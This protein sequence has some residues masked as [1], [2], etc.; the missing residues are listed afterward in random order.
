MPNL[1]FLFPDPKYIWNFLRD[2]AEYGT[3]YPP[4]GDV[5]DLRALTKYELCMI[6]GRLDAY[7]DAGF[8]VHH[9]VFDDHEDIV[10]EEGVSDILVPKPCDIVV[11]AGVTRLQISQWIFPDF[12]RL[13]GQVRPR[14]IG[15]FHVGMCVDSAHEAAHKLGIPCVVDQDITDFSLTLD[16][17]TRKRLR[18]KI[19]S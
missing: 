16:R 7:R 1:L 13:V 3:K 8:T 17:A 4:Y 6:S 19:D 11:P 9:A 10:P 2:A 15:G 12:E 14:V 5:K 18:P